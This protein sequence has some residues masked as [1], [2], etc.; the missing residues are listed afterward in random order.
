MADNTIDS[1][2]LE[3]S[4]D[5]NIAEKSLDRLAK[6]LL[7]VQKSI[8]GLNI[9]NLRQFSGAVKQLGG[10]TKGLDVGKLTAY[11][12][13]LSTLSKSVTAFASAGAKID[14][15]AST[16]E[17][18]SG[19][20][21]SRLKIDGDFSGFASLSAG[22][23]SLSLGAEKLS[24]IKPTEINRTIKNLEKLSGL[25]FSGLAQS[26]SV[27]NGID[28]TAIDKLGTAF[29]GFSSALAGSD[30]VAAGTAKIFNSL[31]QLTASAGNIPL[32]QQTLPLL[33]GE[34]N[35]F[36][37]SMSNAPLVETGTA[38]IVTALAGIA[39]A[40]SKVQK[41]TAALPGLT[42]GIKD[43]ILSLA[44]MPN[45]ST[46]TLRAVEA[47]AKLAPA[48][49]KA[50]A[51]S[52]NLQKNVN[53]LSNSMNSLKGGAGGALSGLK[54]FA[55][56]AL[57]LAGI[58][59]GIYGIG[60]AIKSSV[61]YASDLSEA[62]NVV[63]VGFGDLVDSAEEFAQTSLWSFGLSELAAKQ[64]SGQFAA[65]GKSLGLTQEQAAEM[66]IS[67]AGLTGDL[68]SFWNVSQDVAQ[69]A[70]TSVFTGETESLKKFSVVMTDANLQAFAY[71]QGISKTV[72]AM[73]QAE[74]TQLR[75]AYVME[76]TKTAQGDFLS[77]NDSFA[78][79]IRI[80]SGQFQ[81]LAGII[82]G[83][84]VAALLPV[85]RVINRLMAKVIQ[86]ANVLSSFLGKLF[87]IKPQTTGT[88]A[89]LSDMAQSAG[90]ASTGLESAADGIGNVGKSAQKSEKKL[91]GF[92]AAW[93]EVNNMTSSD[94][95]GS[96]GGAGGA[97]ISDM[98][99]PSEYK[100]DIK[101]EDEA[102]PVLETIRK[103]G[104]ELRDLFVAGFKWG[105]GDT[106]VFDS[107]RAN[108]QSISDSLKQIFTD[109][110]VV[111]SFNGMLDALAYNL[112]V[113]LGAF[114]SIGAT[115]LDNITGGAALYLDSAKERIQNWL[116]DMFDIRS[117]TDTI[118]ANF[119]VALADIFT[120][121]R[122]DEA[123]QITADIIS[124]FA[125][126]FMGVTE[127]ASKFGS[128]IL[129]M[130][131]TPITENASGFK[132]ALQNTLGPIS[133]ILNTL[134]ISFEETWD[135]IN[136]VYDEHIQPLFDSITSG[137]GQIVSTLLDGYNTYMA[138]TLDKLASKFSDVWQG[139][140]QP[141][142][143]N[144]IDLFGKAADLIKIVWINIL[145]P[146][147]NWIASYIWPAV[148]PV[149]EKL[150][151]GFFDTFEYIGR[152]FNDFVVIAG[153]VIDF[154]AG[155]FSADWR[156]SWLGIQNIFKGIWD[157]MP[158]FVKGPIRSIIGFVNMMISGAELGVNSIIRM[159]NK[160]SFDVP[161]WVPEIGGETFGFNISEISLPR[162]PQFA[163]GGIIDKA[164]L[165]ILGEDGAEAVVPLEKN[166]RW[167]DLVADGLIERISKMPAIDVSIDTSKYQFKPVSLNAGQMSGKIQEELEY[168]LSSGGIIDYNRLGQAVY[169]AQSQVAKENP[170]QI[171]D[172]DIFRSARRAQ[173]RFHRRTG[174]TGIAGLGF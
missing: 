39:N 127:L 5:A 67:L 51:A 149:L 21:F 46:N 8:S 34:I 43:F 145:Q 74:K 107:I 126:G 7:K 41:V 12:G 91:N 161:D 104:V 22:M 29:Q 134:A 23:E 33:S 9:S 112:G 49:A 150:G 2:Q 10:A 115:I 160:L 157:V 143:D 61:T 102:S 152:I 69:T 58:A 132:E 40:G 156:R 120:V 53:T 109:A 111:D 142:I 117:R 4:A 66:A 113:R 35:R 54:S 79:Q 110:G 65:M 45:V 18:L 105:L 174:K 24:Q 124:I 13:A 108:L 121:F 64:T 96:S 28:F 135:K 38:S 146:V 70:L 106:S 20:D 32:I 80:L 137:L 47:L 52:R 44:G 151:L 72:S 16:L 172:D 84:L 36:I 75:Y 136:Q 27:L 92:V 119:H 171:G 71:S 130:T 82:G 42:K 99:L 68:A 85:I 122:S 59:G 103:R 118:I 170:V 25:D 144:F 30:K 60:N 138:P 77:T 55:S 95:T 141:L 15:A 50:G 3:I 129:S 123:K 169:Q 48:G 173:Q 37:T 100:I 140:I 162:I 166:T 125:N 165:A 168:A 14:S 147:V 83:G 158:D 62:Q 31:A 148:S 131:L 163:K 86:L 153:G 133:E 90:D 17:K 93:H 81:N 114:T 155:V 154:L 101:A 98:T 87:G 88:G 56:Q 76:A 159:L 63:N 116:I 1:L 164:T 97:S 6:S 57:K 26:A 11:A 139:T 94:D 78:N 73:D 19:L 128:D 89:G 167:I